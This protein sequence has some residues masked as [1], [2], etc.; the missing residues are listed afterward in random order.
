MTDFESIYNW[1]KTCPALCELWVVSSLMEDRRSTVIPGGCANMY[2][3]QCESYAGGEKKYIFEP[4]EPYYFDID[5]VC[6]RAFYADRSDYNIDVLSQA[7]EVCE[8]LIEQQNSGGVPTFEKYPCYMIECLTPKPFI[9]GEY[10]NPGVPG[11]VLV[12]YAV[13]V[14]FY[15]ENPAKKTVLVR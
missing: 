1:L 9:R 15:T 10:R 4:A 14:R 6:Y 3:A 8:W 7:D 5:I 13:T 11:G 2:T 12:D